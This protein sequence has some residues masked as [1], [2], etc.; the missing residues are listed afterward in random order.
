MEALGGE[1]K[2]S[3][4]VFDQGQDLAFPSHLE[5]STTINV[6]TMQYV[7]F[8]PLNNRLCF[9]MVK[10]AGEAS[11]FAKMLNPLRLPFFYGLHVGLCLTEIWFAS[12]VK[13]KQ[14]GPKARSV[15][16]Q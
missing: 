11:D 2:G 9:Q 13:L 10:R 6:C 8:T 12:R 5:N 16:P 1:R 3:G 15:N 14:R 7:V 4:P